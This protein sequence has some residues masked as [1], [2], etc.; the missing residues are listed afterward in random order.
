MTTPTATVLIPSYNHAAFIDEALAGVLLPEYPDIEVV[1]VDDGS[2]DDT[3]DRL[4]PWRE[5]PRL[6]VFTQ[7]NRGAHAALNRGVSLA[8][9]EVVF[10]LNSD[11]AYRPERIGRFLERFATEPELALLASWLEVVDGQG[12]LLG[13]KEGFRNMPPWPRRRRG[14][15]LSD[16]GEP[17]LALVEA[18]YVATTSNVA[19]RRRIFDETRFLALRY[20]HDW[21]FFLGAGMTGRFELIEEPLVR[22]RVHGSNT[23]SEGKEAELGR[24]HMRFEVLWVMARHAERVLARFT[25]AARGAGEL[26]ERLWTSLPPFVSEPLFAQLLHLRGRER[27]V[28]AAY[29]QL[30]A[31]DHPFRR[32]AI[33]ALAVRPG[34]LA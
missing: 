8:R 5:D 17:L 21:D 10:I 22:Y 30:L 26:A 24:G 13:V 4:A 16:D 18:N 15:G 34:D 14:A 32:A 2:T 11:D 19:F 1:L 25:T 7:E 23:I 20:A 6:R 33:R 3:L 28:P 31:E 9:G 29:D 27:R 12:A